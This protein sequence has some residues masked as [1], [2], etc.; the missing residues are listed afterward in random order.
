MTSYPFPYPLV[1][2]TLSLLLFSFPGTVDLP[3]PVTLISPSHHC[4]NFF[5]ICWRTPSPLASKLEELPLSLFSAVSGNDNRCLAKTYAPPPPPSANRHSPFFLT[6][7]CPYDD[8]GN[9][10]PSLL[11][12][13]ASRGCGTFFLSDKHSPDSKFRAAFP[14]PAQGQIEIFFFSFFFKLVSDHLEALL[15]LSPPFP[16]PRFPNNGKYLF[17]FSPS[18]RDAQAWCLLVCALLNHAFFPFLL[19]FSFTKG[20]P[21]LSSSTR[22]RKRWSF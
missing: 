7:K 4:F 18:P 3:L 8:S 21:P 22:R 2:A 20:A 6:R 14:F 10:F 16:L 17:S 9:V 13:L 15:P 5:H 1:G 12:P 19:L 11:P